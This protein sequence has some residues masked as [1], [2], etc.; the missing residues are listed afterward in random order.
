MLSLLNGCLIKLTHW[1]GYESSTNQCCSLRA[2]AS[3]ALKRRPDSFVLHFVWCSRLS[4]HTARDP[5]RM[6][7]GRKVYLGCFTVPEVGVHTDL[8]PPLLP[9]AEIEKYREQRI[10]GQSF[11]APG[12]QETEKERQDVLGHDK[13]QPSK[14]GP[15][16]QCLPNRPHLWSE[17]ISGL[18]C[19][20]SHLSVIRPTS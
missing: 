10:A 4:W 5:E 3:S 7:N 19:S 6:T 16:E 11:S 1:S 20:F 9:C 18:I 15:S 13:I 14:I 17:L 12:I 2:T 8:L